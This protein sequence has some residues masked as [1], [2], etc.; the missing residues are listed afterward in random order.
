MDIIKRNVFHRVQLEWSLERTLGRKS[1]HRCNGLE[2]R[3]MVFTNVFGGN[4][5]YKNM[6]VKIG[7][8]LSII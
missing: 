1:G 6:Y 7:G 2:E 5:F 8:D 3:A 4:F